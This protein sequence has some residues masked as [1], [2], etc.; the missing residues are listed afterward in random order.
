M[1]DFDSLLLERYKGVK[2]WLLLLC[3]GL[4]IIGPIRIIIYSVSYYI[5]SYQ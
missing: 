5:E 2:G 4:T 1:S 3:I